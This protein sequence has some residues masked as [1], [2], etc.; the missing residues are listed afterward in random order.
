M[1]SKLEEEVSNYKE[2]LK[3]E[4]ITEEEFKSKKEEL[5]KKYEA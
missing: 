1:N 3:K 4:M 5:I 2:L